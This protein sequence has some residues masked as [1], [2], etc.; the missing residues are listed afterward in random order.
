MQVQHL[1]LAQFGL[2]GPTLALKVQGACHT[3]SATSLSEVAL[4]R[5]CTESIRKKSTLKT[6]LTKKKTKFALSTLGVIYFLIYLP[7]YRKIAPSPLC[8]ARASQPCSPPYAQHGTLQPATGHTVRHSLPPYATRA[9][10]LRL[11]S[12]WVVAGWYFAA[13][14]QHRQH[15]L[16]RWPRPPV[17]LLTNQLLLPPGGGKIQ[18][19][20]L[21]GRP[22]GSTAFALL[23]LFG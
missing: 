1:H 3:L 15:A 2:A 22:Q 12:S 4:R 20:I 21:L 9:A 13:L 5:T 11:F 10:I 17:A 19:A 6:A 14:A 7:N 23:R 8:G 18:S 16:T